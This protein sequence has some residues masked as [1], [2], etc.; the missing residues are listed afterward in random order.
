MSVVHKISSIISIMDFRAGIQYHYNTTGDNDE[1]NMTWLCLGSKHYMY[2]FS[3]FEKNV[4]TKLSGK[5]SNLFPKVHGLF[6]MMTFQCPGLDLK[7]IY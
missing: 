4:S 2:N 5:Y 7:Q 1:K 6:L 3:R